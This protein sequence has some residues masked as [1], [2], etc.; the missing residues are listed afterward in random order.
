MAKPEITMCNFGSLS[1]GIQDCMRCIRAF[2]TDIW[3]WP[4]GLRQILAL[5]EKKGDHKP[6]LQVVARQLNHAFLSLS[7]RLQAVVT[8]AVMPVHRGGGQ[9]WQARKFYRRRR[10]VWGSEWK[11]LETT[12]IFVVI[13]SEVS[14]MMWSGVRIQA[15]SL[16]QY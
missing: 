13:V 7:G 4:A 2:S 14:D 8:G 10:T 16:L 9:A 6:A 5:L 15:L 3:S 11:L 12:A 1:I